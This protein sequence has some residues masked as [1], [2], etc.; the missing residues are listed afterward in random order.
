MQPK[1]HDT[2]AAPARKPYTPPRLTEYGSV[3]TLTQTG[4]TAAKDHEG[5]GSRKIGG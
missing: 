4:G 3:S 2:A 1:P 5:G